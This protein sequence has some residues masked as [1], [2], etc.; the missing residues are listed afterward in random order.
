MRVTHRGHPGS[1]MVL[2]L[3]LPQLFTVC[4][5]Q[6]KRNSCIWPSDTNRA[7]TSTCFLF[8]WRNHEISAWVQASS[9][10]YY[11]MLAAGEG[12]F[13]S[14]VWESGSI[15]RK[16]HITDRNWT[17]LE[18]D[19][20]AVSHCFIYYS[21]FN[22]RLLSYTRL[23]TQLSHH[24]RER[25]PLNPFWIHCWESNRIMWKSASATLCV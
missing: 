1:K 11:L 6:R 12:E 16:K 14:S 21:S 23:C 17:T 4:G 3:F 19:K 2:L 22:H 24:N 7:Q 8:C 15:D 9:P 18:A 10:Q 13:R 20:I 25:L 5:H